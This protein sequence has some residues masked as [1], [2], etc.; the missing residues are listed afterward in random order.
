MIMR[1]MGVG[2]GFIGANLGITRRCRA[3]MDRLGFGIGRVRH[4]APRFPSRLT[5]HRRRQSLCASFAKAGSGVAHRAF[6]AAIRIQPVSILTRGQ[7]KQ[8]APE[9]LP[10]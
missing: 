2:F 3:R 9:E 7:W 5:V 8:G 1:L 6:P 10:T 4:A